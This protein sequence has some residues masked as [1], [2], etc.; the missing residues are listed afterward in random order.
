MIK[1]IVLIAL[2][3]VFS[4]VSFS[5]IPTGYYTNAEGKTGA[6][7]K[8][9]LYDIIKGH[10]S[11][12]YSELWTA[13]KTTDKTSS[14]TVW[15]VYSNCT[16]TFGANQC[17]NYSGECDCYNREHSFPKSWF[18]G[19]VA[20]MYT[21]LFHLYPTDGYVNNMRG[22]LPFGE[23]TTATYTSGNGSKVGTCSYT[24]YTGVVFEPVDEYKGDF[25][26]SYF[27]M[28]TRYENV[29][30]TWPGCD[31]IDG[32]QFPAFT[33]W[34][35][36]MLLK[37]ST[38]DP[39]SQKEIDRNNAV[40]A[41]Q[42]N[43]NPFIDHSEYAD[44]IWGSGA[45]VENMKNVPIVTVYPNPAREEV[46]VEVVGAKAKTLTIINVIGNKILQQPYSGDKQI[47]NIS[48][49]SAGVYFVMILGDNF[50]NTTRIVVY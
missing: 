42:G 9:A 12:S 16:F 46:T 33:T 49:L 34:A 45:G 31:M 6:G 28:V 18:G 44:A 15:D 8:T 10:T 30:A 21:D 5:Q 20:P 25:A 7:L 35:R 13:F 43:R 32:T 50:K 2:F 47:V 40:Y 11:I 19:E 27:Y 4:V 37:W 36:N 26:R 17:G 22:N 48:K 14:G 29:I 24:G 23:V 41:I 3:L 38:N 39:V 1:K